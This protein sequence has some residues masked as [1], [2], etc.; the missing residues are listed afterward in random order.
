MPAPAPDRTVTHAISFPPPPFPSPLAVHW[1]HDP[2]ICFLNHGSFGGCPTRVLHAQT[3]LR[4]RMEAE[5]IQ[6]FVEDIWELTDR[7]RAALGAFAGASPEDIA[8]VPNATVAVAT[9][10]HHLARTGVLKAGDEFLTNDHEY[11]ACVNNAR[12]VCAMV[13]ARVV[14]AEVPFPIA[15]PDEAYEAIMSRVTPRTRAALIS[16]VTSPSGLVLPVERLV[17]DLEARGVRTI[18]DGAHG[19]GFLGSMNLEA[20]GASYYTSNCHK[21]LCTPKGAAFLW[22]RRDRQAGFRPLVL[23]NFAEKPRPGRAQFLTEFDFVGTNDTTAF[24]VIPDAIEFMGTIMPGGWGA[25]LE[26]NRR[27]TLEAR[28]V[29]CRT[30]GIEPPA[31]ETMLGSLCT[32]IIG[33]H[34]P[35]RLAAHRGRHPDPL[36][37]ALLERWRIQVPVWS[38]AGRHRTVRIS[39]QVYNSIGQYEYLATALKAELARERSDG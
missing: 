8:P 25:V 12:D 26:H 3:R 20:L 1:Q 5:P 9:V 10:L 4:N 24:L 7:A 17:K 39:A 2:S 36:Q 35:E 37:D 18:V 6:F 31:P 15:S 34:E 11:P 32:L 16:H 23:S 28:G 14:T 22:V 19:V 33:P 38:V 13:G 27:L 21:W 29:L 30:L